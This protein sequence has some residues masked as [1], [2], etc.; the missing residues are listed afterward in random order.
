MAT[1][2]HHP[3]EHRGHVVRPTH[4]WGLLDD[5]HH[6]PMGVDKA[7]DLLEFSLKVIAGCVRTREG[8]FLFCFREVI[9]EFVVTGSFVPIGKQRSVICIGSQAKIRGAYFSSVFVRVLFPDPF[10]PTMPMIRF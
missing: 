6:L 7:A 8:A 10:L 5:K 4:K 3:A 1:G 2:T 9:A